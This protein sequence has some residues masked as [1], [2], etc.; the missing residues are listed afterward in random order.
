MTHTRTFDPTTGEVLDP[1]DGLAPAPTQDA[2]EDAAE[3]R[4]IETLVEIYFKLAR[5]RNAIADTLADMRPAVVAYLDARNERSSKIAGFNVTT[6]APV[7]EDIDA[8]ALRNVL[9][10]LVADGKLDE[11]VIDRTVSVS[12][13]LTVH[14]AELNKLRRAG[15]PAITAAVNTAIEPEDARRSLSVK[16]A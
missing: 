4:S 1:P 13:E 16:E 7:G 12:E 5:E 11:S 3:T 2:A 9:I 10:Q 15:D 8:A 6:N 14:K